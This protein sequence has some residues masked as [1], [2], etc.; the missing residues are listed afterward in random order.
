[1]VVTVDAH[2]ALAVHERAIENRLV[3]TPIQCGIYLIAFAGDDDKALEALSTDY[4][5]SKGKKRKSRDD[6]EEVQPMKVR[7]HP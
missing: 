1:M 2:N 6:D 3:C 4:P 5:A 7:I